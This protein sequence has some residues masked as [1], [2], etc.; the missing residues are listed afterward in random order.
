MGSDCLRSGAL[1]FGF[2]SSWSSGSSVQ[3]LQTSKSDLAGPELAA[4]RLLAGIGLAGSA[5]QGSAARA[6]SGCADPG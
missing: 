4:S 2:P 6:G 1:G 5:F 3:G